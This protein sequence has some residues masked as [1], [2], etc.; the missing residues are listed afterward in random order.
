MTDVLYRGEWRREPDA[1]LAAQLNPI[2]YLI[3]RN[4]TVTACL[5]CYKL[6]IVLVR[7]EGFEPPTLWFEAR[8]SI[9]LSYGRGKAG[10]Q[11]VTK[12]AENR[13]DG[14]LFCGGW[15]GFFYRRREHRHLLH[16]VQPGAAE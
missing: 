9:Q 16:D 7:P 2:E 12:L 13:V 14:N 15:S 11:L 1:A 10:K 4:W 3:G 5:Y 8:C 6:L